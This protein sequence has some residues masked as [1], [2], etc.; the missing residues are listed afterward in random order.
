MY[1]TAQLKLLPSADQSAAL[2]RTLVAF[3]AACDYSS[4]V[5]WDSKTFRQFD[6]H[7]LV[8]RETRNRFGLTAQS[9]ARPISKVADSYKL[10]KAGRRTFRPTG[11][12]A[13]DDRILS[14][15]AAT[16]TVSVWSLDG[17]L[18]IPF[19]CGERQRTQLLHRNGETDLTSVRGQWYR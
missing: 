9:A 17:R 1:L 3:N 4:G 6:L 5:A 16:S 18:K 14:W 19:V 12:A 10:D 8:Y 13:Y 2:A 7:A 11:G 15:N